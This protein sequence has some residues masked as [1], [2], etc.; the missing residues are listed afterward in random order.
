MWGNTHTDER[1]CIGPVPLTAASL[2]EAV[3]EA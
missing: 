1:L 3:L 2:P